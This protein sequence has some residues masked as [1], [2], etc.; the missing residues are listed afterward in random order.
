MCRGRKHLM[1][2]KEKE[3]LTY[4]KSTSPQH[5]VVAPRFQSVYMSFVQN[6]TEMYVNASSVGTNPRQTSL[7]RRCRTNV[8]EA[9]CRSTVVVW[10]HGNR[11]VLPPLLDP[12]AAGRRAVES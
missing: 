8:A 9:F 6:P 7:A 2:R 1:M 10:E 12:G 5:V 4:A 3:S 11:G